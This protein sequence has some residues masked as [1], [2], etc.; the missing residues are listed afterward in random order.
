[1]SAV[2]HPDGVYDALLLTAK[3]PVKKRNLT[4]LHKLCRDRHAAG[5]LVFTFADVGRAAEAQGIIKADSL[6]LRQ[7]VDYRALVTAWKNFAN[8]GN[9]NARKRQQV[10]SWIELIP[11]PVHRS[12]VEGQRIEIARLR[13]EIAHLKVHQQP[14]V[15]YAAGSQPQ[16][17]L[18]ESGFQNL[19][20]SE[21]EAILECIDQEYLRRIGFTLGKNGSLVQ[22]ESGEVMFRSG[23]GTAIRKLT[24]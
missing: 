3:H 12:L 20:P 11:D 14:V 6:N 10:G 18:V 23:W 16:S 22:A 9:T 17:G 7:S 24:M 5:S 15:V 19:L 1:M 2:V 4:A 21:K 13:A 8:D